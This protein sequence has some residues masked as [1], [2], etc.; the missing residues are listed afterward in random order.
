[1]QHGDVVLYFLVPTDQNAA[2]AGHPTVGALHY[3]APRLEPRHLLDL[4]GLLAARL[5]VRRE[6]EC[7]GQVAHLVVVITLVQAQPLRVLG[8]RLGTAGGNRQSKQD[9]ICKQ[10]RPTR[11]RKYTASEPFLGSGPALLLWASTVLEYGLSVG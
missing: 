2:E 11:V 3:P 4:L 8:I 5:D 7:L 1:M 6:A 10:N 9:H